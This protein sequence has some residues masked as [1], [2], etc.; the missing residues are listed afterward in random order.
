[1]VFILLVAVQDLLIEEIKYGSS[2][3]VMATTQ[4]P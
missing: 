4:F 3:V 2:V 1:M